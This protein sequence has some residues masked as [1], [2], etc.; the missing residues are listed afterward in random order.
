[1]TDI[2]GN[3]LAD[4]QTFTSGSVADFS[5]TVDCAVDTSVGVDTDTDTDCTV[6]VVTDGGSF[7]SEVSWTLTD[8]LGTVVASGDGF[9]GAATITAPAGTY[10]LNMVDSWGDGWNGAT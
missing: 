2:N 4:G 6:D 3:L 1:M 5:I 7:A 10:T 8:A 9:S